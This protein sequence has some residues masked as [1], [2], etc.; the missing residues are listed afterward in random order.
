MI[1]I[2]LYQ[3]YK[4]DY[5]WVEGT[6]QIDNEGPELVIYRDA[7]G[8]LRARWLKEFT[9]NFEVEFDHSSSVYP[10]LLKGAIY[11][12]YAKVNSEFLSGVRRFS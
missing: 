12:R 5:Y 1:E 3:H 6:T 8:A 11:P 4:G 2:G 9:E 10:E 7:S